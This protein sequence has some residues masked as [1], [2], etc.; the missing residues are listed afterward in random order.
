MNV[1]ETGIL[2]SLRHSFNALTKNDYK[3]C[4]QDV[5]M[6][7]PWA[8]T[9]CRIVIVGPSARLTISP[10]TIPSL[11]LYL[12]LIVLKVLARF[13]LTLLILYASTHSALWTECMTEVLIVSALSSF[14]YSQAD[15]N[16]LCVV[17]CSRLFLFRV[18]LSSMY[19]GSGSSS[20]HHSLYPNIQ[21]DFYPLLQCLSGLLVVK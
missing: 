13:N 17:E 18:L 21:G 2:L 19:Y 9:L 5:L 11:L 1:S 16:K 12:T 15:W 3:G 14:F 10:C 6:D 4:Y 7:E 20:R 8:S